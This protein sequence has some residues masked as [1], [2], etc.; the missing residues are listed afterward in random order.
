MIADWRTA[1]STW[2]RRAA[3]LA[4][5]DLAANPL[6]GLT[7][8]ILTICAAVIWGHERTDQLAAGR[9]LATVAK[10]EPAR[11][12]A[13]FRRY[14][15]LMTRE[16]ARLVVQDLPVERQAALHAHWKRATTIRRRQ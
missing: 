15:R 12:E 14:A 16:C 13:F 9:L 5:L 10:I 11:I 2:Q 1:E 3:C 7:P 6:A 4:F 8:T